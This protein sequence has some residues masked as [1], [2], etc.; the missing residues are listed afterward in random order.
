MSFVT[1]TPPTEADYEAAL[2]FI[3]EAWAIFPSERL[4]DPADVELWIAYKKWREAKAARRLT[5]QPS[6]E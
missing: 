2:R 6:A 5:R 3:F 4:P 1:V